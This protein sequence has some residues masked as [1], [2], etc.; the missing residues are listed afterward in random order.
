MSNDEKFLVININT[1]PLKE[2]LKEHSLERIITQSKREL[3]YALRR[4]AQSSSNK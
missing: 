1:A 2:L 4:A 3:E